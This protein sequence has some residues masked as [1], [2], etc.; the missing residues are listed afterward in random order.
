MRVVASDVGVTSTW[1][2]HSW[3]LE[4]GLMGDCPEIRLGL[5]KGVGGVVLRLIDLELTYR[6]VAPRAFIY[7]TLTSSRCDFII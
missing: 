6:C 3:N 5:Q 1:P 2:V 7:P 4:Q